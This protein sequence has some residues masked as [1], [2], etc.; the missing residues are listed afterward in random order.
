VEALVPQGRSS[1][2]PKEINLLPYCAFVGGSKV[3]SEL[4]RNRVNVDG[5]NRE[6]TSE[7]NARGTRTIDKE[8]RK[9]RGE[10]K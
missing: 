8:T 5:D 3:S 7:L 9:R 1:S 10:R 4:T 6:L 2:S